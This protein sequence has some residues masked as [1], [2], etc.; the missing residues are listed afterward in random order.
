[1]SVSRS[2][3]TKLNK[4]EEQLR[5]DMFE[6]EQVDLFDVKLKSTKKT[7]GFVAPERR[8]ALV[9]YLVLGQVKAVE[10]K[11]TDDDMIVRVHKVEMTSILA[12]PHERGL[13]LIDQIDRER[14]EEQGVTKLPF[15]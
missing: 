3:M 9:A 7:S 13:Q 10:G 15:G 11:E 2:A 8:N 14:L 12:I 6:G 4:K 1:M 5:L